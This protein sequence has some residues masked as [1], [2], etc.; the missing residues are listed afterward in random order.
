[1]FVILEKDRLEVVRKEDE[2]TMRFDQTPGNVTVEVIERVAD[3]DRLETTRIV[4][5]VSIFTLGILLWSFHEK[6]AE[7]NQIFAS[8][9]GYSIVL[10]VAGEFNILKHKHEIQRVAEFYGATFGPRYNK[11]QVML[12]ERT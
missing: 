12:K 9:L 10:L 7:F 5:I 4:E 6:Y 3:I 1:M 2:I 8:M 11:A